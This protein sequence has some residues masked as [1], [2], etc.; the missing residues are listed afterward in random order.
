ML[1]EHVRVL[2]DHMAVYRLIG[3]WGAAADI[4]SGADAGA[5]WTDDAL[6]EFEDTRVQGA[7]AISEMI[8]SDGQ[9]SLVEQGCAHV[10]G[11]PIVQVDGDRAD[12][13]PNYSR[14]TCART[15]ATRSGGCRRTTGSSVGC[16]TVGER[17]AAL[18]TSSTVG[19]RR[20]RCLVVCSAQIRGGLPSWSDPPARVCGFRR[21]E[22]HRGQRS[23]RADRTPDVREEPRRSTSSIF[24][25]SIPRVADSTPGSEGGGVQ[26]SVT[27]N[28][29]VQQHDV[30]PRT[31]L[32]QYLREDCGLTGTKIG[33]DTSSCG[34]CTI[35]ID[36]E[37]VKSCTMFAAQADGGSI[38][39]IEGLA[40]SA[41]ELHPI[42]QA[43]HENHALQCGFCTAGMVM[44][45]VS[46][47][48][49]N[50]T[51]TER[52]VRLG[53]EGNLCRCTGYHNIVQAVLAA[54]EASAVSVVGSRLLRREDAPI[55]TGRAR[56][57]DDLVVHDALHARIVRSP[58]AHARITSIDAS[59]AEA[60]VGV[61]G[62]FTGA[63]LRDEFTAPLPC[64]WNVTEHL[65]NPPHWPL[66]IDEACYAGDGVAVVVA[67]SATAAE[68]AAGAVVVEYEALPAA[69][70]LTDAV[71]ERA[72]VHTDLAS[73]RC[74]TWELIPD[75][76]AVDAAFANAAH[77]VRERYVQQRLIPMAMEPRGVC[78][79]PGPMGDDFTVY[80]ST[81]IPHILKVQLAIVTGIAE[82]S[83]RVVAPAVGGGFGSK[84]NVYAEEVLCLVL[85]RRLGEPVKWIEERG[86]NTL[87]TIQGRGQI[88]DIELAA[89]AAGRITAVRVHL[90][91]DLGAYLQLVTPG[92]PLLG[93]FL[94]HGVYDIPLYSFTC[95]GYFTNCTPTDAYRGAGRPEAT[96]A[97]ERAIESLATAVGVDPLEIR[98]R[99]FIQPDQF[100]YTT[101]AGLVFD[102]GNYE[103]ALD[104]VCG[105]V[106][107][108]AAAVRAGGAPC[109]R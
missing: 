32:V 82:H 16:A 100:P 3:S 97:V 14:A 52:E 89:D 55:L 21:R 69:V 8:D 19:P 37:S 62:V 66:A 64:A 40:P 11:L 5:L 106:G 61:V 94:Y 54:S 90:Q 99:N 28:G 83:L 87:A 31:L 34:A 15:V 107:Y 91:A 39:T 105:L 98:R 104:E 74:Y 75:P 76:A 45:V 30:E 51:P 43:F 50:P 46:L 109:P 22:V 25:D 1:E 70:S 35:L 27:V 86:E 84:L 80:S 47:L 10:Q 60:M 17:H 78:A 93:A 96:Y 59:A 29:G 2:D 4:G 9:R 81:Q 56:Y 49:E 57:V 103:T 6:L 92:I 68:D 65:V 38:T 85:A 71:E 12:R 73:N 7:S 101:S 42:Q 20:E 72:A 41:D 77:V 18:H 48:D 53:L 24:P 108:D 44:A 36:G 95:S 13:G 26:V 88:Q 23:S 67:T 63:D 79:V 102:S 33:C 58:Y